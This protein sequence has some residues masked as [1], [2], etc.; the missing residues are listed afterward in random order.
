MMV[1]FGRMFSASIVFII[2]LK[3]I[4]NNKIHKA[5]IKYMVL[6][7]LFE[8]CLY[9]IF[10]AKALQYTSAA[11]AGVITSLFP[12]TVGIG[13]AFFLKENVTARTIAGFFIAAAGAAWLSFASDVTASAPKPILGNALEFLAMVTGTGYVMFLKKLSERYSPF[14]L[15]AIQA[16]VGSIFFLPLMIIG[17]EFSSLT[18]QPIPF[19]ATLYLG[20]GVTLGGYGLYNFAVS[21]MPASKATA[22]VNLIPVF[23]LIMAWFILNET[24]NYWQFLAC[25]V[26]ASG[27][28]LSQTNSKLKKNSSI[29]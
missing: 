19:F 4:K 21:R 17:T 2:F 29:E 13:A 7:A 24:L 12:I 27:I 8:P 5:D 16:F 15:T 23:A 22:F 10:E 6:M 28:I 18:F 1:I 11:Q 14:F 9:F 25:I 20:V 26:I 3:F